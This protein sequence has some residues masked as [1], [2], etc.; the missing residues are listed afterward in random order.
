MCGISARV[1]YEHVP[2]RSRAEMRDILNVKISP[3]S[4]LWLHIPEN[5]LHLLVKSKAKRN[6]TVH[7]VV[8]AIADP[9]QFPD[10]GRPAAFRKPI[11]HNFDDTIISRAIVRLHRVQRYREA[12]L[13]R[14]DFVIRVSV[15]LEMVGSSFF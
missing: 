6:C 14:I 9:S 8:E 4:D 13:D 5:E 3:S 2:F 15:V 10:E 11:H 1:D 12:F 7:M